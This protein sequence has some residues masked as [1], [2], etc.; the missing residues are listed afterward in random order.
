MR[1]VTIAVIALIAVAAFS[2]TAFAYDHL[3]TNDTAVVTEAQGMSVEASLGYLTA[4]NGWD[5]DGEKFDDDYADNATRL[6]IPVKFKYGVIDKLEVFGILP[7]IEKWDQGDAGE[8]GIG[9]LYVGAK[10]GLLPDALA[11]LRGTL[12]IPL[13]DDDKGLGNAGGFGI[14]AGV[15]SHYQMDAI[16]LCGQAGLR[17]A[18]EDSDTK[19][20]PGLGIY[21]DG[22][23]SYALSDMLSLQAGL[24]IMM[25]GDGKADG[26][27]ID[28]SGSN[29]IELGV[30]GTYALAD[31]M[32]LRG[33]I[34]FDVAGKN[35]N[36]SMGALIRFCY[37][38]K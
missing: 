25:V 6:F 10:Y 13:G 15:L 9:D 26:T 28:K 22:E 31:N 35:Q 19:W 36:A 21:V 12:I 17:W 23:A 1:R 11:T 3:I 24:E 18:A 16:G 30:G 8:S 4:S 34:L 29:L 27:D 38:I 14:D 32:G 7:V 5:A 2:A 37:G 20:Q 33:D